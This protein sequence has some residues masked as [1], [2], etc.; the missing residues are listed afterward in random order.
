MT[1]SEEYIPVLWGKD[2]PEEPDEP[3]EPD[4]PDEWTV[5]RNCSGAAI[6]LSSG[7][8]CGIFHVCV[9]GGCNTSLSGGAVRVT[10]GCLTANDS[11]F[12]CNCS[13]Q[14]GGAI[15][16]CG[17]GACVNVNNSCINGNCAACHGG[18]ATICNN[19][20]GMFCCDTITNNRAS[21]YAG[22]IMVDC[23]GN[24][25]IIDTTICGNCG[26]YGGGLYAR[27]D[28]CTIICDSNFFGNC[29]TTRGGAIYAS[30]GYLIFCGTVCICGNCG[31]CPGIYL[32]SRNACAIVYGTV[33]DWDGVTGLG[34]WCC[35][36]SGYVC[37]LY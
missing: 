5:Y 21:G 4:G 32:S 24:V 13:N 35:C 9:V 33:Y 25:Y 14:C 19:A 2:E 10:S 16:V 22:G 1:S 17:S 3:D 36:G 31:N 8:S 28:S 6:S 12:E 18:G 7:A 23:N 15:Y 34:T 27:D 29:S 20:T 11:I 37:K 30:G 26:N